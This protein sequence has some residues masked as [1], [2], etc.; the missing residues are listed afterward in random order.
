MANFLPENF[1]TRVPG[2]LCYPDNPENP[3][4]MEYFYFFGPKISVI[5]LQYR[6]YCTYNNKWD[7]Y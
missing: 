7:L 5:L 3:F 1:R 2:N 6:I 4:V